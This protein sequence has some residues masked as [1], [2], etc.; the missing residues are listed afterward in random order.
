MLN[1]E[2]PSICTAGYGQQSLY[3]WV[4][5]YSKR[6][7]EKEEKARGSTLRDKDPLLTLLLVLQDNH[8]YL[9]LFLKHMMCDKG[10]Y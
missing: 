4:K 5:D 8:K 1:I 10:S 3:Q 6:C 7:C 2:L 9:P